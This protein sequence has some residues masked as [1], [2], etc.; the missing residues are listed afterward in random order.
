MI[1][2]YYLTR[3]I[4]IL[5]FMAV[6]GLY[7]SAYAQMYRTPKC[8]NRPYLKSVEHISRS[9][10]EHATYLG[11]IRRSADFAKPSYL[12]RFQQASLSS[13]LP[14]LH[15]QTAPPPQ[16]SYQ[17]VQ[18]PYQSVPGIPDNANVRREIWPT[19]QPYGA[20]AQPSDSQVRQNAAFY[21]GH[22]D[23]NDGY[24]PQPYLS[25]PYP[26]QPSPGFHEPR[27]VL[28]EET[29]RSVGGAYTMK[30][31]PTWKQ[32][33]QTMV[34][35]SGR[36]VVNDYRNLYSRD[37][38]LNLGLGIGL[39]AVLSNTAIDQNF[40]NWYQEDVRSSGT[41]DVSTFFK[42][43]GEGK[44]FIPVFAVSGFAYRYL[45]EE[46]FFADRGGRCWFGEFASRTTRTYIVGFPVVLVGQYAMGCSRP[47]EYRSW[48]SQW[49]PFED[50]NAVSGHA[51]MGAAPFLVAA[52]MT[53]RPLLKA[54]LYTLSFMPA[55]SRINDDAHYLSQ[56][57][58][59]WYVSYLSVRA[60]MQTDGSRL[61]KGLTLF[62]VMESNAV[63]IGFHF[64]R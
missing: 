22:P 47:N 49:R 4:L 43:F 37:P 19:Q 26:G 38:L 10:Q 16:G 60:V 12:L 39:H 31:G 33:C 7:R 18:S 21:Q 1:S 5:C 56:S 20:T 63:G 58:L 59:G 30:N 44:Y 11:Q 17:G 48:D 25:Q 8:Y 61:P 35:K 24:L 6:Y 62:P 41:N 34:C 29:C 32:R 3:F 52:E 14:P 64:R 15:F 54:S 36:R 46:G 57:L 42:V 45:Q 27:L 28:T 50:N 51:F 2:S 55:L 53:D 13:D 40:R 23:R 9:N